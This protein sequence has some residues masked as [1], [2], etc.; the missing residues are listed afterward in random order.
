MEVHVAGNIKIE[1]ARVPVLNTSSSQ[2]QN[3]DVFLQVIFLFLV[4]WKHHDDDTNGLP[5]C[6]IIVDPKGGWPC[7][8]AGY[9]K[10]FYL[11]VCY[12]TEMSIYSSCSET[13]VIYFFHT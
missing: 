13:F 10:C 3:K 4:F 6:T 12:E 11:V 7:E 9:S 1:S 8:K 2:I 5:Y